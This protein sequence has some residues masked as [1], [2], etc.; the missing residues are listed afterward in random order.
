MSK[1]GEIELIRAFYTDDQNSDFVVEHTTDGADNVGWYLSMIATTIAAA[2][3]N[4][5]T[6]LRIIQKSFNDHI[7]NFERPLDYGEHETEVAA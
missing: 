4:S 6:V 7:E 5:E 3:W 1:E 2:D